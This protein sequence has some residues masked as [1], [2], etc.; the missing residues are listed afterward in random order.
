MEENK[1]E[2]E[3]SGSNIRIVTKSGLKPTTDS[4]SDV[5]MLIS[6]TP[7]IPQ[8]NLNEVPIYIPGIYIYIYI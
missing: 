1:T 3:S 4:K 7:P 8:E 6:E 5:V 2:I